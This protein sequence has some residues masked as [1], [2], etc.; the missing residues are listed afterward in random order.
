[1][2]DRPEPL[3]EGTFLALQRL[4]NEG[5]PDRPWPMWVVVYPLHACLA[6]LDAAGADTGHASV[7]RACGQRH[8]PFTPCPEDAEAAG[9]DTG[10]DEETT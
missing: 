1:M 10:H 5:T 8:E 6:A 2:T 4:L 7:H 9:A 3:F